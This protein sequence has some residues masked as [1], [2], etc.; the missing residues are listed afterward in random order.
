VPCSEYSQ[1]PIATAMQLCC[2]SDFRPS[3]FAKSVSQENFDAFLPLLIRNRFFCVPVV[4]LFSRFHRALCD[5]TV[6]AS[7]SPEYE[8][9]NEECDFSGRMA[10]LHRLRVVAS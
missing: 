3:L 6:W 4:S 2:V 9:K 8:K 10:C 5:T 7:S 1:E